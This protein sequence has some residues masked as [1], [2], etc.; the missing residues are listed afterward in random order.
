MCCGLKYYGLPAVV[1]SGK[2]RSRLRFR[3][4]TSEVRDELSI[5]AKFDYP[6]RTMNPA[7][8]FSGTSDPVGRAGVQTDS[9]NLKR[10]DRY[11]CD[12][13]K[14]RGDDDDRILLKFTESVCCS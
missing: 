5:R 8:A 9:V 14:L 1:E 12:E 10:L 4:V 6:R 2:T 11:R 3:V 13:K 7:T